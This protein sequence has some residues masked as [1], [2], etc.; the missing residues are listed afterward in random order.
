VYKPCRGDSACGLWAYIHVHTAFHSPHMD[1]H[2]NSP[3]YA[4]ACES[5]DWNLKRMPAKTD[6]YWFKTWHS[7]EPRK[8]MSSKWKTGID[9]RIPGIVTK[10]WISMEKDCQMPKR[11]NKYLATAFKWT[12]KMFLPSMN[13]KVP[14]QLWA[15]NKTLHV[16]KNRR[17]WAS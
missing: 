14:L 7:E 4:C 10:L 15:I 13:Q 6:T 11:L 2:D 5:E 9:I 8:T 3:L 1:K 17:Q 16:D 12:N